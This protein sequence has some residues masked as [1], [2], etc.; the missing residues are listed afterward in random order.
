M[1]CLRV[2]IFYVRVEKS[3]LAVLLDTTLVILC[4]IRL[5]ELKFKVFRE[6]FFKRLF[7][8]RVKKAGRSSNQAD[9]SDSRKRLFKRDR[10][11]T[12][13]C[14]MDSLMAR[15]S[16]TLQAWAKH[17]PKLCGR[18]PSYISEML[19]IAPCSSIFLAPFRILWALCF[20]SLPRKRSEARI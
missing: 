7:Y 1:P 19:P 4:K 6:N 15:I 17:P 12:F 20:P 2:R 9:R 16:A 13:R 11:V 5:L 18:S 10:Q 14:S 8:F 3:L